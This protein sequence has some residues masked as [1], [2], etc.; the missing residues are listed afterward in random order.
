MSQSVYTSKSQRVNR[1]ENN[2]IPFCGEG[3]ALDQLKKMFKE[4]NKNKNKGKLVYFIIIFTQIFNEDHTT[5]YTES[6]GRSRLYFFYSFHIWKPSRMAQR[7]IEKQGN[8]YCY[9]MN[10]FTTI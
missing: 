10:N 6:I 8:H 7:T 3:T 1:Q 4:Q 2:S 5:H 9:K